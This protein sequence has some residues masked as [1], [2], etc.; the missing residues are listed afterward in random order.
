MRALVGIAAL[1]A[2]ATPVFAAESPLQPKLWPSVEGVAKKLASDLSGIACGPERGGRRGCVLVSDEKRAVIFATLS[3]GRIVAGPTMAVLAK[4]ER[5][6]AGAEIDNAEADLEAVSRDGDTYWVFGSAS[7]KRRPGKDGGCTPVAARRHVYRFAVDP[8]TDLPAF[9]VDDERPAPEIRRI[10]RLPEILARLPE[11]R[12]VVG[13]D[14]CAD[15]GGFN[16]EGGAVVRGVMAVGL[17]APLG[18][19]GSALAVRLDAEALASGGDPR[20]RLHRLALGAGM[21]IRDLAPA[22]GG[23]LV[24]AGPSVSDDGGERASSTIWFWAGDDRPPHRLAALGGLPK[25]A[26]PEGLLVLGEDATGFRV[27]VLSDGVAG[28]APAE[29][30]LPRR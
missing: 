10:D 14:R 9:A 17:R 2:L 24:L 6:A 11:L 29:Y 26:K 28:G 18:P 12:D 5:D 19:D 15:D 20:P 22:A 30:R 21:G 3:E 7:T 4:H 1:V 13:A 8:A 23:F 25:K 16:I 27:L